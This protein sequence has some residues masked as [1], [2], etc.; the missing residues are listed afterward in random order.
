MAET[1]LKSAVGKVYKKTGADN[2]SNYEFKIYVYLVSQDKAKLTSKVKVKT[3][4]RC[5]GGFS[6]SAWN[7][8]GTTPSWTKMNGENEILSYISFDTQDYKT[9]TM[10]ESEYTVNHNSTTGEASATFSGG[11]DKANTSSAYKGS[12]EIKNVSMPD[13]SVAKDPTLPNSVSC[14]G[15]SDTSW[16]DVTNPVFDVS[17]SGAT[18]GTYTISQYSV[19]ASKDGGATWKNV[20]NLTTDKTSGSLTDVSLSDLGLKGGETIKIR[21]GMRTS[22]GNGKWWGHSPWGGSFKAFSYPSAPTTFNVPSSQEI[23]TTFNINW[24]GATA[25]SNGIAGYDLQARA[26]NGSTWTGWSDL[27]V[28]V[29]ATSYPSGSPKSLN[30]GGVNY[31]TYGEKVQFQYRIRTSDGQIAT[32]SWVTK[33]M[34]IT[35]NSPSAPRR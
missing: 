22:N 17:W 23:D 10:K 19:D 21:I 30:I 4:L 13:I 26:Y 2:S 35:I 33:T 32:S 15:F 24:S 6:N 34:A 7:N 1:L 29:N 3:T 8:Y 18:K 5:I 9:A 11:F 14:S 25:G 28:C 20:G 12:V 31:A 16:I 27:W